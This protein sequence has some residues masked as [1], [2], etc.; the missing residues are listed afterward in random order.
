MGGPCHHVSLEAFLVDNECPSMESFYSSPP[1]D[2]PTKSPQP[3]TVSIEVPCYLPPRRHRFDRPSR[4]K[5]TCKAISFIAS[6]LVS[7]SHEAFVKQKSLVLGGSIVEAVEAGRASER[8]KGATMEVLSKC[9][10]HGISLF[11]LKSF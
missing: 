2:S 9:S 10:Y 8:A 6:F 4:A 1:N 7:S 5:K 11:V 3:T